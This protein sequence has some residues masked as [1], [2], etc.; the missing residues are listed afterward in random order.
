MGIVEGK[1][2]MESSKIEKRLR[3]IRIN[4]LSRCYNKNA[5]DYKYYGQKGIKLT[6]KMVQKIILLIIA[7]G[8]L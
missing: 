4:M 3:V 7:D 5:K 1:G 8:F 2:N 6:E